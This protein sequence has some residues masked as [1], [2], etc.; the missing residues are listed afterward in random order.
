MLVGQ[1]GTA[2]HM[3]ISMYMRANGATDEE[4]GQAATAAT[5]AKSKTHR[6][7]RDTLVKAGMLRRFDLEKRNGKLAVRVELT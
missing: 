5:G 2:V 6:V 4:A 1:R 3:A 7:K